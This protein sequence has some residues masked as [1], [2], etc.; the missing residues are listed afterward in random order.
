[1]KQF[2]KLAITFML[3]YMVIVSI[4]FTCLYVK[5][6]QN[7]NNTNNDRELAYL[8]NLTQD[9]KIIDIY[10]CNDICFVDLYNK[11]ITF[12]GSNLI[13]NFDTFDQLAQEIGDI[14]ANNTDNCGN[15]DNIDNIIR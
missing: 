4:S 13:I 5:M 6:W 9:N 2:I 15:G 7:V 10:L 8:P 12:E 14:T 3:I 1:M 11:Q